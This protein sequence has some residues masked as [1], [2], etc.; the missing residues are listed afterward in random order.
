MADAGETSFTLSRFNGD[1]SF[2]DI[3]VDRRTIQGSIALDGS[4][5]AGRW[6]YGLYY[7]H[8]EYL[9]K[10][11]TPGFLTTQNFANAVDPRLDPVPGDPICRHALTTPEHPSV[12]PH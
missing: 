7:S 5:D 11:T 8:G 10:L 1:L 2:A 9:N 12:P 4:F 6:R 3:D